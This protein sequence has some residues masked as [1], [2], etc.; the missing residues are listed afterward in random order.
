MKTDKDLVTIT[1]TY[2]MP[3]GYKKGDLLMLGEPILMTANGIP[4]YQN[5]QYYTEVKKITEEEYKNHPVFKGI[6]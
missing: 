3:K 5:G 1:Q 2:L 4:I 6:K